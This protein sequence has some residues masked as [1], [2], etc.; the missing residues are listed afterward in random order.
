[1]SLQ[2]QYDCYLF[3]IGSKTQLQYFKN[4]RGINVM[5]T[6]L[7]KKPIGRYIVLLFGYGLVACL[8]FFGIFYHI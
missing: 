4:E 7:K 1:M 2:Q 8:G 3:Q 5:T 6:Q